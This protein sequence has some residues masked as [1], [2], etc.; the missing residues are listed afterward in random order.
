MPQPPREQEVDPTR[1]LLLRQK[2]ES[3]LDYVPL[4]LPTPGEKVKVILFKDSGKYYTEEF[5]TVPDREAY[6]PH[7]MAYSPDFR[8]I[9]NGKVLVPESQWGFPVLL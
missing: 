7:C 3:L 9:A 4:V 5:W 1:L 6:G 2:V 8:R